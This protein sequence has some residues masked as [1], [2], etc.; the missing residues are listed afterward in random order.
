MILPKVQKIGCLPKAFLF[1][2]I[3]FW[4][5]GDFAQAPSTLSL[6]VKT[7]NLLQPLVSLECKLQ[8]VFFNWSHP[9]KF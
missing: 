1:F 7:V 5:G 2:I 8:G 4:G 9:E 6:L 3:F